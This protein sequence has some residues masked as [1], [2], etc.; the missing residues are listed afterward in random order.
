MAKLPRPQTLLGFRGREMAKLPRPQILL[1][2]TGRV[3]A[4][5]QERGE[6][7]NGQS[8]C[9]ARELDCLLHLCQITQPGLPLPGPCI[10]GS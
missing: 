5:P 4:K 6:R 2:F 8:F 9:Q 7:L 1:G 3:Q 10:P